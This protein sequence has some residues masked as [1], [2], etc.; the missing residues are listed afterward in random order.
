MA[1]RQ[2]RKLRANQT[3]AE[4]RLWARLRD[5]QLGGAKFRRQVPI[6]PYV[7]DFLCYSA[8]LIIELDGGQHAV[9]ADADALWTESLGSEGFRVLRFWNND[10]MANIDRVL[11]RISMVLR[12]G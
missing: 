12:E 11:Q 6:G 7:A 1:N 5:R 4:A 3:E 2:A 10:V 8:R 9:N